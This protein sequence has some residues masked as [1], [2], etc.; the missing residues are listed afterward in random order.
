MPAGRD[1]HYVRTRA[2]RQRSATCPRHYIPRTRTA[3]CALLIVA[4]APRPGT[5][6]GVCVCVCACRGVH[7]G[8]P[9]VGLACACGLAQIALKTAT[10]AVAVIALVLFVIRERRARHPLVNIELLRNPAFVYANVGAMALGLALFGSTYLVPLF[11]Q[12][13]LEFTA[14]EAGLLMLPAGIVLGMTFPLA[15][16]LADRLSARKLVIFGIVLFAMSAMLFAVSDIE[17]A[18]GWLALWTVLGR[19]GIG[20]MLPALSTGALNPLAPEQL[21]AGSST[22]NFTRQLGGAFGVNIV[23]LTIEFGDHSGGIPTIGAFHSAW[24]LV[25]V[26]VAMA[27]IPVWKMRV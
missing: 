27:A 16:R 7:H 11:V 9:L 17:L 18:F 12:T 6:R 1:G 14:T 20:F 23:A 5:R 15:G 26:F 13:A 3:V 19:I 4:I 25:A 22:I 21:G 10:A 2:E 8:A 24:W